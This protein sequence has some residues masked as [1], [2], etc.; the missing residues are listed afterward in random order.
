VRRA[1]DRRVETK[2]TGLQ[3]VGDDLWMTQEEIDALLATRDEPVVGTLA[4]V[5]AKI[6]AER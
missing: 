3:Q 5:L 1:D 2:A 4:E 6:R